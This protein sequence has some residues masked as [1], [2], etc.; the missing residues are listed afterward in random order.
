LV[1]F[2]APIAI[3]GLHILGMRDYDPVLSR[4]GCELYF[5]SDRAGGAGALDLWRVTIIQ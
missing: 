5:T 1:S 4:D 2:G 3:P